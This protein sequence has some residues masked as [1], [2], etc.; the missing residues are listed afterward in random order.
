MQ[1]QTTLYKKTIAV[2]KEVTLQELK[3]I[4]QALEYLFG[5]DV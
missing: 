3:I 5:R 1:G 4:I 2:E